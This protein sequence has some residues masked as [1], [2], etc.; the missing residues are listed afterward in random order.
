MAEVKKVLVIG[1]GFSGTCAAIQM[2]KIGIDVEL[3]ETDR[4]WRPIGAGITIN[5]FALRALAVVGVLPQFAEK[6]YCSDGVDVFTASGALMLSAP[7]PRPQ[8]AAPGVTGYSGIM[9]PELCRILA[10]AARASGVRVRLGVASTSFD[11]TADEVRVGFDD[12]STSSYDLVVAA[13]GVYSRT[14]KALFPDAPQPAYTGQGVWRAVVPRPARIERCSVFMGDRVKLGFNPVSPDQMYMFLTEDRAVNERVP[15]EELVPQLK[16]L[17]QP[18][19]APLVEELRPALFGPDSNIAYRPLEGLLMPQPWARGR[20]VLIG[21]AVHATTPHLGAGAGIGIE[22][23][24]V[25]AEELA[26]DGSLPEALERFQQRRWERCRLV[27]HNSGRLGEIE[28]AGG[29]KEEHVRLTQMSMAAL[30]LP[31]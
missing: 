31:I 3:V 26:R 29:S 2:R 12:G 10:N 24:V 28:I 4:D 19:T 6:G 18:F 20:V 11:Q 27:V 7:T 21:D 30:A 16:A 23:A 1:G 15:D 8:G 17:L 9:R 25:L 14:R 22:D 5:G 13:D